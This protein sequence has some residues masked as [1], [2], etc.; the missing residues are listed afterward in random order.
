[1]LSK[2]IWK[3]LPMGLIVFG[4]LALLA[5]FA[6]LAEGRP[7]SARSVTVAEIE[8]GKVKAGEWI[9]VED[10]VLLMSR[11]YVVTEKDKAGKE[12]TVGVYV[13]YVSRETAK[14]WAGGTVS[15]RTHCTL[16]YFS[17]EDFRKR[18]SGDETTPV[19]TV[20]C[21]MEKPGAISISRKLKEKV[22]EHGF[23]KALIAKPGTA[24]PTTGESVGGTFV[25]G[26]LLAGGL[27]WRRRRRHAAAGGEQSLPDS[28]RAPA[29]G[30]Q[31]G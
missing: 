26:L 22:K 20:S 4:A 27:F 1:M 19:F 21:V 15:G 28:P 12:V 30:Q 25:G 2:V 29:Q 23:E 31:A 13:P 18:F 7:E 10:G 14:Q 8:A 9:L 16:V 11:A 24:P 3:T 6:R 17:I 5:G